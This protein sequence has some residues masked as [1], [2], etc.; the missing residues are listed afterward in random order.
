MEVGKVLARKIST[1]GSGL[2]GQSIQAI[3]C[4]SMWKPTQPA[5]VVV[6]SVAHAPACA[7]G[8]HCA[9]SSRSDRGFCSQNGRI[10]IS[11]LG[12]KPW[13]IALSSQVFSLSV[14]THRAR[15]P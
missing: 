14:L 13:S 12:P 9:D 6:T 15:A 11:Q 1:C 5:D 7:C 10:A 3:F 2:G 8:P 4:L